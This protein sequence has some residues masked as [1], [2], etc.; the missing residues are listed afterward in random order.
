MGVKGAALATILSQLVSA[1]WVL[2]FLRSRKTVL[3]IR[4]RYFRLRAKVILP[5]IALGVSPFIMQFTE[6][7][8]SVCF[9]TQ[10]LKYGGDLAV[11]AMTIL[12][13][14]MQFSMLPLMGLTQGGQPIISYNYGAGNLKRVKHTFRLM[15]ISCLTYSSLVWAVCMFTPQVVIHMFT[16]NAELV[17][18][19]VEAIRVYM[20]ASWCLAHRSPVSRRSLRLEM[21]KL[22][23]F[24]RC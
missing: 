19:T 15:L 8:L 1:I 23:F 7:I 6:G 20:A 14:A 10:L 18:F 24:W 5:C 2:C 9:N 11:G 17:S 12:N 16:S 4:P 13:S 22:Q 3:H 21:Q